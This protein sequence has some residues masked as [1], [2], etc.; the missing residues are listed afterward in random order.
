MN[1]ETKSTYRHERPAQKF[2]TSEFLLSLGCRPWANWGH[3]KIYVQWFQGAPS[4][5]K[6]SYDVKKHL[7]VGVGMPR[8]TFEKV[9]RWIELKCKGLLPP[10][11]A[12]LINDTPIYAKEALA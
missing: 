5:Y 10:E 6:L 12:A 9:V 2:V 1:I 3:Q 11:E 8:E 4:E 7:W